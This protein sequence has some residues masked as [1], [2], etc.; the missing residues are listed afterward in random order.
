M[1]KQSTLC[2]HLWEHHCLRL[3]HSAPLII[4]VCAFI[5]V[6]VC[7]RCGAWVGRYVMRG[8]A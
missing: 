7:G 6:H 5:S 4:S 2:F 3:S 1:A 8:F